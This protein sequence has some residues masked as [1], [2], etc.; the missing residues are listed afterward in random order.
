MSGGGTGPTENL[1]VWNFHENPLLGPLY[2]ALPASYRTAKSAWTPFYV[3]SSTSHNLSETSIWS[4]ATL[5]IS[6]ESPFLAFN[7]C[8]VDIPGLQKI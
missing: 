2:C 7:P 4:R 5:L 1:I 3:V 8:P 6:L